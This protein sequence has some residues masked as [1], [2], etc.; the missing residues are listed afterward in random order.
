MLK[1]FYTY[2]D[3]QGILYPEE[4]QKKIKSITFQV[5]EN[6]NLNCSYCYQKNKSNKK[7]DFEIA[8]RFID[9]IFSQKDNPDSIF[10][11]GKIFGFEIEFIGGEPLLEID[12]IEQICDY[13]E[14]QCLTL[15]PSNHPWIFNHIYNFSTNG[16]LYF[17]EK[18]QN[19]IKKYN[20]SLSIGVTV[21]GC[22]ELHDK[23]RKNLSGE[24]S[25][26]VAI[27][28][29]LAEKNRTLLSSTKITLSPDNVQ[30]TFQGISN[31]I[32]LGFNNIH[33]NC[34]FEKGWEI[35]HAKM[36]YNELKQTIDWLI[37]NSFEDKCYI[38][39]LDLDNYITPRNLDQ[40]WCGVSPDVSMIAI[41]YNG[42]FFPCIRF[43][44][45]SIG[46]NVKP[47]CLGN[48]YKGFASTEEEKEKHDTLL[49]L[50]RRNMEKG[51][52]CENCTISNGCAWCTGY[53]YQCGDINKKTTY[54]CDMHRAGALA[55][56]YLLKLT[57]NN[58]DDI[59]IED[60]IALRIIS[61]E[62]L[63]KIK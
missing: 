57:K 19:F 36:L 18:V 3:T 49:N 51:L 53:C 61:Q 52:E 35:K 15:L 54:H 34:A 37:K 46:T 43:M 22:K 48:I 32:D 10:Y 1:S 45:S 30:Y 29:A 40:N 60:E 63:E 58:S 44:E 33:I 42:D 8:K 13:F 56:K 14:L 9:L 2:A 20:A 28:A 16:V 21:D 7:M 59:N 41:D 12:L 26:D 27:K 62:E 55:C 25:Y 6:C 38:S 47:Y 23:C 24:G 39:I 4:I 5:T 11:D 50:K 17:S 31:L